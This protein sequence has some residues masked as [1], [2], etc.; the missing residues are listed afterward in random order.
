MSDTC[1]PA[2]LPI[3]L[4]H[5]SATSSRSVVTH[6][7]AMFSHSAGVVIVL[8]ALYASSMLPSVMQ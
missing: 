8:M 6:I 3:L 5:C 1:D 4:R 7:F 2:A